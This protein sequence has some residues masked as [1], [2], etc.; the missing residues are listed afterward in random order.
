MRVKSAPGSAAARSSP[1]SFM[2]LLFRP[3]ASAEGQTSGHSEARK[4]S[5]RRFDSMRAAQ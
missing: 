3:S 2:R 1:V 4:A 5:L